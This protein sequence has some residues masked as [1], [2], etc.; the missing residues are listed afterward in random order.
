MIEVYKRTGGQPLY[1]YIYIYIY[2]P[3]VDCACENINQI[4]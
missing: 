3:T 4:A 2:K 1:I